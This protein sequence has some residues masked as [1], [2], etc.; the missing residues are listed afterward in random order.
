MN[1]HRRLDRLTMVLAVTDEI[2]EL[3][4]RAPFDWDE[5]NRLF[6]ELAAAWT[7]EQHEAAIA[8]YAGQRAGLSTR[9]PGPVVL[10][11]EQAFIQ[12]LREQDAL[13]L[14]ARPS[15]TQIP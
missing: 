13:R 2:P 1:Y 8:W 7:P 3:P 14:P 10:A 4:P 12:L 15:I 11:A 9:E 5:Y 6:E